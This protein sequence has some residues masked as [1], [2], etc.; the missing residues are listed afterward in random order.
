MF[1]A[2]LVLFNMVD[3]VFGKIGSVPNY[4]FAGFGALTWL[5]ESKE[6]KNV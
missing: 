1:W 2:L 6:N 4:I 5:I 3:S